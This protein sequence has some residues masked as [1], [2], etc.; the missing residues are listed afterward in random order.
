MVQRLLH[1]DGMSKNDWKHLKCEYAKDGECK[2]DRQNKKCSCARKSGRRKNN[3]I[4]YDEGKKLAGPMAKKELR[5]E[6]CSR[7]NGERE[8]ISRQ[9][10]IS[11]DRQLTNSL[12]LSNPQVHG[13]MNISPPYFPILS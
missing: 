3:A 7:R 11:D 1:Y 13:R 5:A 8:E 12:A 10:K 6:G 4:T 2:L 9:K